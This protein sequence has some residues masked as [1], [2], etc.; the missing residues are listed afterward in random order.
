MCKALSLNEL[1]FRFIP[2]LMLHKPKPYEYI[3][4]LFEIMIILH[5]LL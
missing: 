4:T 2:T 5:D 1:E 3:E